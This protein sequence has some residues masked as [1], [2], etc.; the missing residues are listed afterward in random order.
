VITQLSF[1]DDVYL[2][3][4]QGSPCSLD[5]TMNASMTIALNNGLLDLGAN[6]YVLRTHTPNYYTTQYLPYDWDGDGRQ[7]DLWNNYV[8]DTTNGDV[9]LAQLLQQWAG[10]CLMR[11][12]QSQQRFMLI[13]G[14]AGTGKSVFVDVLTAMV[15]KE[16]V[17]CV[18]LAMLNELHILTRTYGKMLNISD[19]SED[20]ILDPAIENTLKT[21]TGGT[22]IQFKRFFHEPFEAYPTAKIVIT[23][24]HRPKFKD[25][26]DGVWRRMLYAQFSNIIKEEKQVKGLSDIIIASEMPAVLAWA[27]QGARMLRQYGRFI[28][29][30]SMQ[31]AI[32]DYKKEVHPELSFFEDNLEENGHEMLDVTCSQV[33]NAYEDWCKKNGY[34]AKNNTNLGK[35]IKKYFPKLER[36]QRRSGGRLSWIYKGITFKQDSEYLAQGSNLYE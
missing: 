14:E 22:M 23:T 25:T 8:L 36:K 32:N 20:S 16:N 9:E 27:L 3:P 2:R 28:E 30:K 34:G 1:L 7:S 35:S 10:Y 15:G 17:S 6:P 12:D 4:K 24:N 29:P 11:H 19:E 21:Y 13:V 26:S 31:Q 5:G 33:R 18:P